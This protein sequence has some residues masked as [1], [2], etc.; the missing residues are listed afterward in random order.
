MQESARRKTI[1]KQSV[2]PV[3]TAQSAGVA[4]RLQERADVATRQLF[5][6]LDRT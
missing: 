3:V 1:P 2:L 6:V 4:A 5:Q